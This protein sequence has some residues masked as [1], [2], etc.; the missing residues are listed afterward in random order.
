MRYTLIIFV[1]FSHT[2]LSQSKFT[3][4]PEIGVNSFGLPKLDNRAGGKEKIWPVSSP[5]LGLWATRYVANHVFISF[6][7]QYT[8]TSQKYSYHKEGYDILNKQP[9][10]ID[11]SE[12]MNFA[13][14]SIP[15]TVGYS[16]KIKKIVTNTFIGYTAVHYATGSYYYKYLTEKAG[17]NYIVIEK[18]FNPFD[19]V[20]LEIPA[21][22][23]NWGFVIGAGVHINDAFSVNLSFSL[24]M[25]MIYF[26][27]KRPPNAIWD[28]PNYDHRYSRGDLAL[29]LRYALK[30]RIA[31]LAKSARP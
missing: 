3:I 7:V 11:I 1:I 18:R 22:N 28:D 26:R 23:K 27:E 5:L 29:T 8:H 9:Y 13:K 2:V 4:V 14:V 6:G 30:K 25:K 16:F 21:Q 12:K 31:P 20:N 17:V 24:P 15:F 19:Q 10:T